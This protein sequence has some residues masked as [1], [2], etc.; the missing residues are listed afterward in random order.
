M[1]ITSLPQIDFSINAQK[2]W[3]AWKCIP[4]ENIGWNGDESIIFENLIFSPK[5]L[6]VQRIV[7]RKVRNMKQIINENLW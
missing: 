3:S 4:L 7:A 1:D 5:T 2:F 6:E